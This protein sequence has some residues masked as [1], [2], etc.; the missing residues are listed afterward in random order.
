MWW[1]EYLNLFMI[2]KLLFH[3]QIMFY[4]YVFLSDYLSICLSI[5]RFLCV[6]ISCLSVCPSVYLSVCLYSCPSALLC[7][8]LSIFHLCVY[9][10]YVCKFLCLSIDI[11]VSISIFCL[12]FMSV[13]QT[14]CL[15]I[16]P[17]AHM[18]YILSI[19][20]SS[21]LVLFVKIATLFWILKY[22][23]V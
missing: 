1:G 18:N 12:L 16:C 14:E 4:L 20:P 11:F 13:C 19:C 15:S 7:I 5:S 23:F 3:L 22:F 17:Y 6:F 9:Q 21:L 2:L 8:C 10:V